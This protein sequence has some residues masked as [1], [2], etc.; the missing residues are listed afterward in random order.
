MHG[1]DKKCIQ[2]CGQENLQGGD[3]LGDVDIDGKV[4]LKKILE[5]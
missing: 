4:I 2:N 5:K 3:Q 1:R